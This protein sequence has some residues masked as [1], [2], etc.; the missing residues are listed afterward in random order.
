M[1]KGK[2]WL[3]KIL[4]CIFVIF[5]TVFILLCGIA[6]W[7]KDNIKAFILS[8]KYSSVELLNKMSENDKQLKEEIVKYFPDGIREFT[9]EEEEQID[10]GAVSEKQV[11]AKILSEKSEQFETKQVLTEKEKETYEK[12]IE[13]QKKINPEMDVKIDTNEIVVPENEKKDEID[14]K[15]EIAVIGKPSNTEKN[16]KNEENIKDDRAEVIISKYVSRL[17]NLESKYIGEIENVVSLAK[18]DAKSKG[19]TKKDTSQLL[20]VGAKYTENINALEA[21][22]DAEVETIIS[23]LSYELS[24]IGADMSI[25]STIRTAYSNEKSLK[26]AYYMNMVY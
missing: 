10:S 9:K 21:S 23:N 11:L 22:C 19:L 15:N 7:Q 8:R 26:R 17:Y 13:I 1:K 20:A 18:S 6:M 12:I 3:K 24:S 5:L 4:I 2:G 16:E 14:E 25:I